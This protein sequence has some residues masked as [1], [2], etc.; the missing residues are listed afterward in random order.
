M[1]R[2]RPWIETGCN[3]AFQALAQGVTPLARYAC[4]A[5]LARALTTR[6]MDRCALYL[7]SSLVLGNLCDLGIN[8]ACI[9]FSAGVAAGR[10]QTQRR[11]LIA[12]LAL[13]AVVAMAAVLLAAPVASRLLHRPADVG[14]LR[15]AAGSAAL[16]AVAS[17]TLA[18]LQTD[19][20][21][22]RMAAIAGISAAMQV[23]PVALVLSGKISGLAVLVMADLLGKAVIIAANSA[24]LA[25]VVAKPPAAEAVGWSEMFGFARWISLSMAVGAV[26]NYIP[27]LALARSGAEA[28]LS[29]Y[30][31]GAGLAGWIALPVQAVDSVLLP[32][33]MEARDRDKRA[34]YLKT[35]LPATAVGRGRGRAVAL[36]SR[37]MD[38]RPD[39]TTLRCV[40][41]CVSDSCNW[42]AL[43]VSRQSGAIPALQPGPSS[44]LLRRRRAHRWNVRCAGAAANRGAGKRRAVFAR[45]AERRQIDH[46]RDHS[47]AIARTGRTQA[48]LARRRL[49]RRRMNSSPAVVHIGPFN[50][51]LPARRGGAIERRMIELASAQA[52]RGDRVIVFSLGRR[53]DEQEFSGFHIRYRPADSSRSARLRLSWACAREIAAMS[54]RVAHLHSRA[55]IAWMLRRL[56][57]SVRT[58]LSCDYHL[59][60][61]HAVPVVNAASRAIWK[62]C[63][64]SV[65]VV[66]PVSEYC[67]RQYT[68]RWSLD[69]GRVAVIPNGV[70]AGRFRPSHEAGQVWRKRLGLDGRTVALY[71]GRLC[72][73]KGT[74]L[75]VEAWRP[76]RARLPDARL[77]AV[78]PAD[79]FGHSHSNQVMQ[80]LLRA[81]GIHVPPV[82]D[83]ELAG[84]YNMADVF[85]MPTR[86]LEMFGLAAVE[87]QACGKPVV[88]SD[89]GGLRETVTPRSGIHF[90]AG[91]AQGLAFALERM[92]GSAELRI[93][94]SG[95]ARREALRFS[96]DHIARRCEQVYALASERN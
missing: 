56:A 72:E 87:A 1:N 85:V 29:T 45:G 59:E 21:F 67:A 61:L 76:V 93:I 90:K 64:R 48:H 52:R 75:L 33:A 41:R 32:E 78:G 42:A 49:R 18:L 11:L 31:L 28:S 3:A 10:R 25:R 73:Q 70:D 36:V 16:G 22:P 69:P 54:P 66:S 53:I 89:Q 34:S 84:V 15:L 96:W 60:P 20:K 74:D 86:E 95:G 23:A 14:T 83:D 80:D 44:S 12:R 40:N 63:L 13:A 6:E 79:K 47:P 51:E 88:A 2:F 62:H 57:P 94:L 82:E 24:M 39:W 92:L 50:L 38:E 8:I 26:S 19:R 58:V 91:D 37:P 9:K 55:E 7:A 4:L 35:W 81:G 68:D 71:V 46:V 5:M 43:A 77:V 65:S 17:F 30:L 27:T